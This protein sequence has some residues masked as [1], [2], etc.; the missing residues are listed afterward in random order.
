LKS[1]SISE[2]SRKSQQWRHCRGISLHFP[3][4]HS[5]ARSNA[6]THYAYAEWASTWD[7]IK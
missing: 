3:I 4:L 1:S 6:I 2:Q 7:N 5:A